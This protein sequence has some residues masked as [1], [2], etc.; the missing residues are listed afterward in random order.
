[1]DRLERLL[2]RPFGLSTRW[3]ILPQ[4]RLSL[5]GRGPKETKS[6]I[7]NNQK[8]N[9]KS[10]DRNE[11]YCENHQRKHDK[12]ARI[13]KKTKKQAKAMF[14][15]VVFI[16]LENSVLLGYTEQEISYC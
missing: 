2:H 11:L 7:I 9:K 10:I 6:S 16:F 13:L 14:L 15:C 1:M 4:S 3:A 5:E 8:N 12:N